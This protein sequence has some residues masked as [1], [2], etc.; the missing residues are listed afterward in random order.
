MSC[1]WAIARQPWYEQE[2][3]R[4]STRKQF[5]RRRQLRHE[6]CTKRVGH[7]E[8]DCPQREHNEACAEPLHSCGKCKMVLRGICAP[9]CAA[10][11]GRRQAC[12]NVPMESLTRSSSA[13]LALACGLY[14]SGAGAALAND[15]RAPAVIRRCSLHTR[16]TLREA[17]D[18][19]RGEGRQYTHGAL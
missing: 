14:N 13:P 11:P 16:P 5:G 10:A 18:D 7:H 1:S 19:L 15:S 17:R 6:A 9:P 8:F 12:R 4:Q 2:H 3:H